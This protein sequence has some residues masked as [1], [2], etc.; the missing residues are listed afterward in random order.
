MTDSIIVP[1]AHDGMGTMRTRRVGRSTETVRVRHHGSST[2]S[3]A[4]NIIGVSRASVAK[5]DTCTR[6]RDLR[7]GRAR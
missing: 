3:Y 5:C 2:S 6:G 4:A 1:A 7:A